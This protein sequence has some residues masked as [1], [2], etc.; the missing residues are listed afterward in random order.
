MLCLESI[1][2]QHVRSQ[3]RVHVFNMRHVVMEPNI[4]VGAVRL[5]ILQ[6]VKNDGIRLRR[7]VQ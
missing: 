4:I 1:P 6:Y 3:N 5:D 7:Y 2:S